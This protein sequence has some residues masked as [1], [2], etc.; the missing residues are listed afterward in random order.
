[1]LYCSVSRHRQNGLAGSMDVMMAANVLVKGLHPLDRHESLH[2]RRSHSANRTPHSAVVC[3]VTPTPISPQ[4][5]ASST[6]TSPGPRFSAKN[7]TQTTY[8]GPRDSIRLSSA[9]VLTQWPPDD[10]VNT[11]R[12]QGATVGDTGRNQKKGPDR[13]GPFRNDFRE[14]SRGPSSP[15]LPCRRPSR[16]QRPASPSLASA[17]PPPCNPW[18]A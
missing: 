12:Y 14:L 1:M 4:R 7:V 5:S 11:V 15:Y 16:A 17:A 6:W 18:S 2:Q 8:L 9:L 3:S 10:L 13:A